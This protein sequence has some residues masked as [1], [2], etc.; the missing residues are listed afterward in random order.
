MKKSSKFCQKN[1][2]KFV[3]KNIFIFIILQRRAQRARLRGRSTGAGRRLYILSG[4]DRDSAPA[5]AAPRT[6]GADRVHHSTVVQTIQ[7]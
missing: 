5:P 7:I 4:A 6:R 2:I 3:T 1:Y